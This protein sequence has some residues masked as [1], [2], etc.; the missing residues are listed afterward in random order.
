VL[1]LSINTLILRTY[2][3]STDKVSHIIFK[4]AIKV[5]VPC[6]ITA[7]GEEGDV[8]KNVLDRRVEC[9][10]CMQHMGE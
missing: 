5:R 7:L 3:S 9:K 6:A 8:K 2:L 10:S 4:R 1:L